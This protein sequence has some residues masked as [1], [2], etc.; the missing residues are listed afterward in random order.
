MFQ[1]QFCDFELFLALLSYFAWL[2]T[3]CDI[4]WIYG[5]SFFYMTFLS[6]SSAFGLLTV[7]HV[8]WIRNSNFII[9]VVNLLIKGEIEKP[10]G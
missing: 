5:F 4:C 10:S 3:F 2:A 7:L 8:S 6:F 9:F 1:W